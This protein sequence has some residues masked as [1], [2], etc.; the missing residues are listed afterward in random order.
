M[1]PQSCGMEDARRLTP[2]E[3]REIATRA[4]CD[5]RTVVSYLKGRPQHSTTAK[6][7]ERAIGE[8]RAVAALATC[9]ATP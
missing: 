8:L 9:G 4:Y 6:R 1:L 5:P 3:V 2:H 7:I